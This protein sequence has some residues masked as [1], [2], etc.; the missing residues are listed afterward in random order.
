MRKAIRLPADQATPH[1]VEPPRKRASESI[2]TRLLPK[3]ST[4]QPASGRTIAS[5][6]R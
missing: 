2:H 6:S 1:S 5:A 3:R 4:D